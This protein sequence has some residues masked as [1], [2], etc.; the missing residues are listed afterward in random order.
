MISRQTILLLLLLATL[1]GCSEKQAAENAEAPAEA[2]VEGASARISAEAAR[3]AGI[4]ISSAGPAE[5][6][7]TLTF[8]GSIKANAEREQDIRVR[9]PGVLRSVR[10]RAGDTVG[11]GEVLLTVESNE[12]L[13]TYP[14]TAPQG[15]QVLERSAN[16]GDAVDSSTVLMKVVDLSTVWAEFAVFAKDLAHVRR[17]MPVLLRGVDADETGE[18]QISYIAPAGH[19]DSQSVVARAVIENRTG[20]WVPGQFISADV[21]TA[22]VKVPVAVAPTALQ[23][24]KGDA[25]VFVETDT[26]F[27]PRKVQTGRRSRNAVEIVSGLAAGERYAATSSYLIKAE[28]LKS[29][30]EED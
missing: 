16:P 2:L 15:G 8:Y 4:E 5:I 28:V 12:S 3:K 11:K 1:G 7:E 23:D 22:D 27:E 10:K 30:A 14:V 6:R 13:Q 24:L 26:G 20:Q 9:Y 19:S 18:A 29:E 17:G 25:V 21:V